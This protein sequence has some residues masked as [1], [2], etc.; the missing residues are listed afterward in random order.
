MK[1]ENGRQGRILFV[2]CDKA[3]CRYV[4]ATSLIVNETGGKCTALIQQPTMTIRNRKSV[5]EDE[6]KYL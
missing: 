2:F 5:L 1:D 3:L 6:M 4:L